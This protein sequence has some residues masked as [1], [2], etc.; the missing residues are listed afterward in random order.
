MVY[1][2]ADRNALYTVFDGDLSELARK[3]TN[4]CHGEYGDRCE[5][6]TVAIERYHPDGNSWQVHEFDSFDERAVEAVKNHLKARRDIVKLE[7][8]GEDTDYALDFIIC[9]A[10]N[11]ARLARYVRKEHMME[12]DEED[13][14]VLSVERKRDEVDEEQRRLLEELEE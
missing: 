4:F 14:V 1:E 6:Y 8:G 9:P 7:F 3:V 10:G 5:F 12:F 13:L 11:T 2:K